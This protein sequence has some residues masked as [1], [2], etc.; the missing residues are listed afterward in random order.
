MSRIIAKTTDIKHYAIDKGIKPTAHGI[1]GATGVTY[2]IMRKALAGD[3]V[4]DKTMA[5]LMDY[6]GRSFDEL[7]ALVSNGDSE[8]SP[9]TR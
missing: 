7:F 3:T 9:A 1:A 5:S 4:S 2:E 8:P 6:F